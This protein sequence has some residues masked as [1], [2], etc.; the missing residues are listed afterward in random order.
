M[1]LALTRSERGLFWR[2]YSLSALLEVLESDRALIRRHELQCMR[3]YTSP[4]AIALE[5]R[6]LATAEQARKLSH[7]NSDQRNR[8]AWLNLASAT[9]A[10]RA[11]SA[12]VIDVGGVLRGVNI[13]CADLPEIVRAEHALIVGLDQLK[14]SVEEARAFEKRREQL[15]EP[16]GDNKPALAAPS[17]WVRLHRR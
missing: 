4:Q 16:D 1:Q 3:L 11:G 9:L 8:R 10:L 2:S 5:S 17:T 6:A 13:F 7:W 14:A 15:F 12:F